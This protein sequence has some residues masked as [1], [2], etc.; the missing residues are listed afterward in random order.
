MFKKFLKFMGGKM[1][2][3]RMIYIWCDEE[4]YRACKR[5]AADYKNYA[6]AL[7]SLLVKV[8]FLREAPTF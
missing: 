3:N 1:A 4:L 8:G 5:Y 6:E 7:K 2:K